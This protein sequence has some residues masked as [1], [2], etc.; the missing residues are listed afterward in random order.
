MRLATIFKYGRLWRLDIRM[1]V[2]G[3]YHQ[4]Y[5]NEFVNYSLEYD[6]LQVALVDLGRTT[7]AL[8]MRFY[9]NTEILK[10]GDKT[11]MIR[12]MSMYA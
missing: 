3:I 4:L 11:N 5:P 12:I 10:N 8:F 7:M 9:L 1:I 6:V 2:P